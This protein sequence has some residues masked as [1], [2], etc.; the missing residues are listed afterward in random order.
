MRDERSERNGGKEKDGAINR[1]KSFD[2]KGVSTWRKSSHDLPPEGDAGVFLP[3]AVLPYF[4]V[5]LRSFM[6]VFCFGN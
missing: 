1:I 3:R 6:C 2:F 4:P 5:R